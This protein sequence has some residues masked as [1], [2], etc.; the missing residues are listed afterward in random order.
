[1]G[2]V[3]LCNVPSMTCRE[4]GCL[5]T[6]LFQPD[7]FLPIAISLTQAFNLSAVYSLSHR[8]THSTT[9]PLHPR[10]GL[11]NQSMARGKRKATSPLPDI[12]IRRARTPRTTD[13]PLGRGNVASSAEN[14]IQ[15]RLAAAPAGHA[16]SE[17]A[18]K[19][20][21]TNSSV[22][23]HEQSAD[24]DDD[25]A[26]NPVISGKKRK[27]TTSDSSNV[28]SFKERHLEG[29]EVDSN[30]DINVHIPTNKS[31][32]R[33]RRQCKKQEKPQDYSLEVHHQQEDAFR[34]IPNEIMDVIVG[35][36]SNVD[37]VC[38]ALTSK[39]NYNLISQIKNALPKDVCPIRRRFTAGSIHF[40]GKQ[41]YF[42]CTRRS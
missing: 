34:K 39:D 23:E 32:K 2:G 15:D 36:I 9:S 18:E 6:A 33:R 38:F 26:E 13:Q 29:E 10:R 42:Y 3:K 27:R 19:Q 12:S 8:L 35:N 41:K 16:S 4:V 5:K 37:A 11:E 1:M 25:A 17:L 31:S 40:R 14:V 24:S 20:S 28:P 21:P 30:D 7:A 22:M